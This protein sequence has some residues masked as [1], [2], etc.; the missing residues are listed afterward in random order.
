MV[1]AMGHAALRDSP[2]IDE[3]NHLVRGLAFWWGDARLSLAHPPLANALQ[4]IPGVL[5]GAADVD[6]ARLPG[7]EQQEIFLTASAYFRADYE[8]ARAALVASRFVTILITLLLGIYLHRLALRWGRLPS[9]LVTALFAASP[10]LL[11]H[12]HLVTTDLPVTA[13]FLVAAGEMSRY[14][15]SGSPVRLLT[16]CLAVAAAVSSKYSGFFLLPAVAFCASFAALRGGGLFAGWSAPRR[17]LRVLR[18]GA[19]LSV[20]LVV[21]VGAAYRFE[22]TGWRADRMLAEPEPANRLTAQY[23]GKA[24]ETLSPVALLPGWV[25]VPLP[26]TFVFGAATIAAQQARGHGGWFFGYRVKT[27]LY[28]PVMLLLKSPAVV[29]LLLGLALVWAW[30]YRRSPRA[31]D[32]PLCVV[33]LVILL[34]LLPSR[35]QIGVRHAL[36]VVPFLLLAAGVA[37]APLLRRRGRLAAAGA[38]A[39]ALEVALTH[40]AYVSHFSWLLGGPAV[41]H[42]AS[43]IGEDWGQDVGAFAEFAREHR[44]EPLHYWPYNFVTALELRRGGADF[45]RVNCRRDFELKGPGWLAIHA[46]QFVRLKRACG[47]I[48]PDATPD[49]VFDRH[50]LVFRV[51]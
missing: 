37:A 2:T 1:A 47:A 12:G 27:P 17:M 34:V 40:P 18:D 26:Y 15:R 8:R 30:R 48:A 44:L 3:P 49:L 35:I 7:W 21:V 41:G 19:L 13:A 6:F 36:P 38:A 31:E 43:I 11:A 22:R 28:F 29:V 9:L 4:A 39:L 23:D 14:L 5:M 50:I 16:A 32:L 33:P 20:V 10:V 51:P 24:L 45:E 42:R 25:P 46:G